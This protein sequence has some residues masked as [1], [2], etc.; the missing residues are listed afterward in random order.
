MDGHLDRTLFLSNIAPTCTKAILTNAIEA[1]L[2]KSCPSAPQPDST[3]TD[4]VGFPTSAVSLTA[5]VERVCL[6]PPT[7]VRK[8][9]CFTRWVH[10][11]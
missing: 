8:R 3:H 2:K 6:A 4:E 5:A 7:W 1:A 11:C 10:Y 9:D